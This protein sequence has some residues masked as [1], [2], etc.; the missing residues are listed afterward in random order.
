MGRTFSPARSPGGTLMRYGT[1]RSRR[2]ASDPPALLADRVLPSTPGRALIAPA[3]SSQAVPP[4][5]RRAGRAAVALATVAPPAHVRTRAAPRTV[6]HPQTLDRRP[7]AAGTLRGRAILAMLSSWRSPISALLKPRRSLARGPGLHAFQR[8]TIP[9]PS[10]PP[11]SNGATAQASG[12]T[13]GHGG[14]PDPTRAPL[15]ENQIPSVA[16]S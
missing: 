4:R 16:G 8:R 2:R 15:L 13:S 12:S 14:E 1:R 9:T 11:G 3:S 7:A 5:G 6:E 10:G